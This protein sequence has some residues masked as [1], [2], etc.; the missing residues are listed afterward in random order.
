MVV[1]III[2][3]SIIVLN[4]SLVAMTAG[5]TRD[6][7]RINSQDIMQGVMPDSSP[8][9]LASAPGIPILQLPEVMV[10]HA[11]SD[12]FLK[13]SMNSAGHCKT[14]ID[15]VASL[16]GEATRKHSKLL[17]LL[18]NVKEKMMLDDGVDIWISCLE[19]IHPQ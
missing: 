9:K 2:S 15:F 18:C 5:N 14:L 7:Y 19:S 1:I 3:V 6:M 8:Q 16:C 13:P 10:D 11:L 12:P 17:I 4:M